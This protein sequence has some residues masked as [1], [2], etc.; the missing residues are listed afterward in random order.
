[1]VGPL[2]E[3]YDPVAAHDVEFVLRRLVVELRDVCEGHRKLFTQIYL[4]CLSVQDM[5]FNINNAH[6]KAACY[7]DLSCVCECEGREEWEADKIANIINVVSLQLD[8]SEHWSFFSSGK[9]RGG[10]GCILM[11]IPHFNVVRPH[12]S[13]FFMLSTHF[14]ADFI[15]ESFSL[16]SSKHIYEAVVQHAGSRMVPPVLQH[17]RQLKPLVLFNVKTLHR[18]LGVSESLEVSQGR[19]PSTTDY[20]DLL[21]ILESMGKVGSFVMHLSTFFEHFTL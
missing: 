14:V 8:L 19:V 6:E 1:M 17:C 7:K 18:R 15:I 3:L 21:V 11:S 2:V 9:E 10:E 4:L 16:V 5:G 12:I 13:Q 20:I